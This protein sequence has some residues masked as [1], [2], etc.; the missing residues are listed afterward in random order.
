MAPINLMQT[1][2]EKKH[3]RMHDR[4]VYFDVDIRF[5]LWC[6]GLKFAITWSNSDL[7]SVPQAIL[8]STFMVVPYT[9]NNMPHQIIG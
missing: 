9:F 1:E 7:K 6:G 8:N 4:G 2:R 3:V 5:V